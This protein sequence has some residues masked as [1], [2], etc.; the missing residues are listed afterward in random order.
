MIGSM[1][2][3]KVYYE[4]FVKHEILISSIFCQICQKMPNF[5][6]QRVCINEKEWKRK[7]EQ[8]N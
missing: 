3:I 4:P 2:I 5:V 6:M 1:N 8:K 7:S